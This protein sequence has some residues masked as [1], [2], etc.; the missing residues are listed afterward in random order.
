MTE[1]GWQ[2]TNKVGSNNIISS[3]ET[4]TLNSHTAAKNS[5]KDLAAR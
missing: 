5:S 2:V 4:G 3:R 1:E